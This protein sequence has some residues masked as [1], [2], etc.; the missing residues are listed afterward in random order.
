MHLK[1]IDILRVCLN[2]NKIIDYNVIY[3]LLRSSPLGSAAWRS[4]E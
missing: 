4:Q 3:G 2:L 1:M